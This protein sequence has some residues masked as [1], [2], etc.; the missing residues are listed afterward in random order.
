MIELALL[1]NDEIALSPPTMVGPAESG[2]AMDDGIDIFFR[3]GEVTSSLQII[4][5]VQS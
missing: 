5:E 1:S 2:V 4:L 3:R